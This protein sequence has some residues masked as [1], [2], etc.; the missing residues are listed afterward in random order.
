MATQAMQ[1]YNTA[2][3]NI[4]SRVAAET[5]DWVGDTVKLALFTSASNCATLTNVDFA[6]LTNEVAAVNGYVAGGVAIT[7]KALTLVGDNIQF[8]G[9]K[10]S[11][12]A[13]GG[14]ITARFAVLYSDTPTNK[15]LL[16]VSLLDDTPANVVIN[17][18]ITFDATPAATGWFIDDIQNV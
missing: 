17:D 16:S 5:V 6:D 14:S 1:L 2:K 12:T 8:Q 15:T 7:G 13:A 3:K 11:F 9:S 4:A 18:G 10:A